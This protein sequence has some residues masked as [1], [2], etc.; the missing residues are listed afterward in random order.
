VN[1]AQPQPA[2]EQTVTAPAPS[3]DPSV[4]IALGLGWQMVELHL[5]ASPSPSKPPPRQPQLPS[6]SD[7]TAAQRTGLGLAQI[8]AGLTKLAG[9]LSGAGIDRPTITPVEQAFRASPP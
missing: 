2:D 1:P 6:L 3:A 9:A 8:D 4:G 5:S 7:L